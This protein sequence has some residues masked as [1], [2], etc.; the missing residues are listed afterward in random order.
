[1]PADDLPGRIDFGRTTA[2]TRQQQ[3]QNIEISLGMILSV[4]VQR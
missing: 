3:E 2:T 1:M 4:D